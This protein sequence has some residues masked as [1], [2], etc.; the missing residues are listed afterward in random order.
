MMKIQLRL[1]CKIILI[2]LTALIFLAACSGETSTPFPTQTSAAVTTPTPDPLIPPECNQ[3][4]QEWVSPADG[5]TLVCVPVGEFSMGSANGEAN[6]A[7]VH[8]VKLNAFWIDKTE[9]T[10]EQYAAYLNANQSD[11]TLY[12]WMG[13]SIVDYRLANGFPPQD[14]RMA[15][16]KL[17]TETLVMNVRGYPGVNQIEWKDQQFIP[18]N[19]YPKMPIVD[20]NWFAADQYCQWAGRRLPTE[21]E[22]EKAARGTDGRIYTWGNEWDPT[23]AKQEI[24]PDETVF[25]LPPTV[26]SSPGDISPYGA[27]GMSGGVFEW[28]HDWYAEDY[29][30]QSP[31]ENPTGPTSGESHV[32]RA[33]GYENLGNRVFSNTQRTTYRSYL[34][35]SRSFEVGFRC[36][37]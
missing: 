26:D 4:G 5:A 17:G 1:A 6:E 13:D 7:P 30:S 27:L 2:S 21:A 12:G 35:F 37:R 28:V 32:I 14:F 18:N 31:I 3:V 23:K 36:A 34:I 19:D 20:I 11:L 29:Y 33:G 15:W 9:V 25:M 22:W 10:Q 8:T 24:V 16:V